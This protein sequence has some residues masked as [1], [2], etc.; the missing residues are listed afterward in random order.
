MKPN[1]QLKLS[2]L[3]IMLSEALD[4]HFTRHNCCGTLAYKRTG[5]IDKYVQIPTT[6]FVCRACKEEIFVFKQ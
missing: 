6:V 2:P 4:Y 5:V 3:Q 1:Q